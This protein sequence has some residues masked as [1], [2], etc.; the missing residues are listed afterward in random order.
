MS[1]QNAKNTADNIREAIAT[2]EERVDTITTALMST[3]EFA[4]T[5]NVASN[6]QLRMK[7]GMNAHMARQLS[8]FNMPSREDITALGERIMTMDDRLVRIEEMLRQIS[9]ETKP[10]MKTRTPRTKKPRTRAAKTNT[11]PTKTKNAT[12]AKKTRNKSN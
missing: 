3:E 7:Q 5:A 6:V 4:K 12:T 1:S 8:M 11:K 2:L 10:A 9:P